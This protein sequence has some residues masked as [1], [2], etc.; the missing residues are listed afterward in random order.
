MLPEKGNR[1]R[2]QIRLVYARNKRQITGMKS[3][4]LYATRNKKQNKGEKSDQ[5]ML[6]LKHSLQ[7]RNQTSYMQPEIKITE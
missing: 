2:L 6:E 7:V 3:D 1:I 5:I 4:L